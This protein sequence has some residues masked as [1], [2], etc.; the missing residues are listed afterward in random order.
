MGETRFVQ[1][2]T[3]PHVA[4]PDLVYRLER[5]VHLPFEMDRCTASKL[6]GRMV[7][8]DESSVWVGH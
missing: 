4:P 6:V 1:C 2:V 3:K 5:K 8:T 7:Q